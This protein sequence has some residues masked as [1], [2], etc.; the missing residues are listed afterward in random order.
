MQA[1]RE[2]FSHNVHVLILAA[3][4]MSVL[5]LFL[6][7]CG[8]IKSGFWEDFFFDGLAKYLDIILAIWIK[9]I[10]WQA[11]IL[12]AFSNKLCTLCSF[13]GCG[14]F[15]FSLFHLVD[16]RNVGLDQGQ[17]FNL[18]LQFLPQL[19]HLV[20]IR[21]ENLAYLLLLLFFILFILTVVFI[22]ILTFILVLAFVFVFVF[23]RIRI[24]ILILLQFRCP[25]ATT[26]IQ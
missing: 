6:L 17:L 20:D 24:R 2:S 5:F 1:R 14:S 19:L 13:G 16:I 12:E 11:N 23:V 9:Q 25:L 22:F 8:N 26:F 18:S 7:P 21:N 15:F 10:G 3:P 4:A